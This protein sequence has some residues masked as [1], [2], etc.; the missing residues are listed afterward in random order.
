[1]EKIISSNYE[2]ALDYELNYLL[3]IKYKK[4]GKHI[5]FNY[6]GYNVLSD[7]YNI[8]EF[9]YFTLVNTI[10]QKIINTSK[11][12][13]VFNFLELTDDVKNNM[14]E[15]LIELL[16]KSSRLIYYRKL[17]VLL[18]DLFGYTHC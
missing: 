1:M 10:N 11:Q 14:K 3:E 5:K 17:M 7:N 16:E 6:N 13:D 12:D 2:T 8:S 18:L 15:D 9:A 4:N